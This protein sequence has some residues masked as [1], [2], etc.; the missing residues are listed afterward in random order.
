MSSLSI[1]LSRVAKS[2]VLEYVFQLLFV[3]FIRPER[4]ISA[5]AYNTA[6]DADDNER[7]DLDLKK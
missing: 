3:A 1:Y 2:L 4:L 7:L 6:S 5:T